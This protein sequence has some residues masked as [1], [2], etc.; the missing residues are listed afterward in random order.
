MR[1][2]MRRAAD[3]IWECHNNGWISIEAVR[4]EVLTAAEQLTIESL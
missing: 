3:K 1:E 4:R 2:G